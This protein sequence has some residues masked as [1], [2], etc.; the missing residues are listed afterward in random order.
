VI[1][2]GKPFSPST[3]AIRIS[4]TPRALRSLDLEPKFRALGLLNPEA[5]DLFL[6]IGIEGKC[7]INRFVFDKAFI[8]NFD[9][10][11]VKNTIG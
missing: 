7:D 1:A 5:D 2:S 9:P 4:L 6:S 8:A 10:Q 3:T 11:G